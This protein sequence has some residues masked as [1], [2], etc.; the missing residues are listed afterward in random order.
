MSTAHEH[1]LHAERH[2]TYA[3][4]AS[5]CEREERYHVARAQV[6]ATLALAASNGASRPPAEKPN[7]RTMSDPPAQGEEITDQMGGEPFTVADAAAA[8]EHARLNRIPEAEIA[9]WH[10]ECF[11]DGH[12]DTEPHVDAEGREFR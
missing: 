3:A 12:D 10:T 8:E 6:H 4:D 5:S 2:L 1:Y 11:N 9:C 7:V